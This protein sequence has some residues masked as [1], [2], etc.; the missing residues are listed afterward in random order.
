[1]LIEELLTRAMRRSLCCAALLAVVVGSPAQ[2]EDVA[3]K[4]SNQDC[5]IFADSP[6][7]DNEVVTW[8][9]SCVDEHAAG[10]GRL[11]WLVDDKLA[12]DYDGEMMEGRLHG[13]GLLRFEVEKGKGFDRFVGTFAMGKPE[14]EARY[15][16]NNGDFY[17]GGFQAGE[18]HGMG[19]YRLVSGEEY[20]GEFENGQRHGLG[21]LIAENGDAYWGEFEKGELE[22]AGI[23]VNNDGSEYQGRFAN[24]LP[25]GPGTFVAAN[26][27]IYQGRFK[28]GNADGKF[29]VTKSDGSQVLETWKDGEKV[30]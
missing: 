21:F 7:K 4:T 22:G 8:S 3:V 9:G 13:T 19:Y 2:A 6:L 10:K 30:Q 28:A 25:D 14:G 5:T 16:A 26:G 17:V 18:R 27:D 29:L 12:G 23:L 20:H 15:D 1:M 11:E 24:S